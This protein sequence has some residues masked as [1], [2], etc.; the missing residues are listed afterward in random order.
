MDADGLYNF[1]TCK[2]GGFSRGMKFYIEKSIYYD[3]LIKYATAW[4]VLC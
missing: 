3:E 4:N 2:P 1:W